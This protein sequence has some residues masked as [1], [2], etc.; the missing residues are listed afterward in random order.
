MMTAGYGQGPGVERQLDV[1][2]E[3]L[4]PLADNPAARALLIEAR[5]V[6][7]V[8]DNWRS[9]P[10][11]AHVREEMLSR[12]MH[13]SSAMSDLLPPSTS[14]GPMHIP[15]APPSTAMRH[16]AE[17]TVITEGHGALPITPLDVHPVTI[18]EDVSPHLAMIKDPYSIRADAYRAL[19]HQLS[20][21]GDP[22]VIG[23][24]SAAR[25]EGKT[26]AAINLAAS[27]R[28]GARGRVLI[29]EANLRAPSIAATLGFMPPTCFQ[30]Q[31]VRHRREPLEPWVAAEVLPSLHA[32]AINPVNKYAPLVDPIAFSIAVDR[33]RLA[34]YDYIVVDTPPVLESADVNLITDSIDGFVL[35]TM[36]RKSDAR[37]V[38]R[39]IDQIGSTTFLG[40][41][42]LE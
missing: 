19:R 42:L 14:R 12:V 7:S 37:S 36:V 27:L 20:K 35:A 24:T 9:V 3:R 11:P 29:L 21:R 4:S 16:G 30:E 41:I 39:A 13:L 23:V 25:R 1:M 10:P 15:A 28:E 26:T 6:R 31:L 5:R 2:V 8:I 18:N 38:R 34:G 40:S 22:K 32:I 17:E 33:L